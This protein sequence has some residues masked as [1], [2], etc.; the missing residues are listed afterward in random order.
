ML[1]TKYNQGLDLDNKIYF[2]LNMMQTST[3]SNNY[4]TKTYLQDMLK[5]YCLGTTLIMLYLA[6]LNFTK[7]FNFDGGGMK[8]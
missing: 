6:D 8:E 2:S 5:K 4:L 3:I 7:V 1:A